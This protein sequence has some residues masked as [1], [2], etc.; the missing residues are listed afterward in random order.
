MIQPL[1][2]FVLVS[3]DAEEEKPAGSM[4]YRPGNAAEAK[5]VKGTVIAVGSG[6]ITTDGNIVPLEVKV[7]D[8]VVFNRNFG[9]ELTE[10]SESAVIIK[11][12]SLL[13]VLK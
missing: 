3:R 10:G 12:E 4:I 9:T 1:R 5:I 8:R 11:E 2:D 6:H 13:A 7:G